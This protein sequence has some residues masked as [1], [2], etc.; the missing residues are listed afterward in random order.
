MAFKKEIRIKIHNKLEGHCAYC[1]LEIDLK[2]MQIDHIIPQRNFEMM[3]KNNWRIPIFLSHLTLDDLNNE[4]N[5]L[6]TCRVCN[7][8]KDAFDLE[9]FR[10]EIY[11]QIKRLNERSAN[12]RMAKKY[13]LLVETLKP[14][15]F[16]FE[17]CAV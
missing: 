7:K 9:T 6:P 8:L 10:S 3:I 4:D 11:Q 16:Y 15:V 2:D 5:L 13:G 1:G 12:Y 14:I 17:E